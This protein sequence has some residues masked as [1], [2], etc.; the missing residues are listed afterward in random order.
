MSLANSLARRDAA[1]LLHPQ[2]DWRA[3][4]ERGALVISEAEI[5]EMFARFGRA[6]DEVAGSVLPG[7][8]AA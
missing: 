2:T 4:E 8:R 5:V 1:V 7:Q 3:H 6:L